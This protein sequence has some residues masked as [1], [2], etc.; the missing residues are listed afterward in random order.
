VGYYGAEWRVGGG[1]TGCFEDSP[2]ELE[3]WSGKILNPQQGWKN[4]KKG[5]I[6]DNIGERKLK[7]PDTLGQRLMGKL[8]IGTW[9]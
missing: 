8:K 2:Q 7:N 4:R 9:G 5:A 1:K 6:C 3:R